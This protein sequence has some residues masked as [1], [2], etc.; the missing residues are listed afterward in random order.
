MPASLVGSVVSDC[1]P[2]ACS[3]PGPAL[4]LGLHATLAGTQ[5]EQQ[6][7]FLGSW[8]SKASTSGLG[9]FRGTVGINLL[10]LLPVLLIEK[11]KDMGL[12]PG[13]GRSPGGEHGSIL[14]L[15]LQYSCLENPMDRGAWRG[16][17]PWGCKESDT[18]EVT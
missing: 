5:W 11:S 7:S 8:D 2:T 10:F 9:T 16:Y 14:H 4:A 18:T 15:H 17:N 1:D 12:I 3:T 13:S 6:G